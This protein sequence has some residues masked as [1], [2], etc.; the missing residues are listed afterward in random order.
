MASKISNAKETQ[1][2]L[3][4]VNIFNSYIHYISQSANPEDGDET[5]ES[6][7]IKNTSSAFEINYSEKFKEV[8]QL[9]DK[10][11]DFYINKDDFNIRGELG[12][13]EEE[14]TEVNPIEE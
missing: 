5:G 6:L 13:D 7:D 10:Y 9:F 2:K 12:K 14:E 1:D 3:Q 8:T 4:D 11:S